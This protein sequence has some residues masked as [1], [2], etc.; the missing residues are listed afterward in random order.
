ML[1]YPKHEVLHRALL[2]NFVLKIQEFDKFHFMLFPSK[3]K[4]KSMLDL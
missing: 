4:G 3:K 2:Q 1:G